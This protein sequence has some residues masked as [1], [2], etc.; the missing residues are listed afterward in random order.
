MEFLI[1][2][3]SPSLNLSVLCPNIFPSTLFSNNFTLC[4]SLSMK[5]HVSYPYKTTAEVADLYI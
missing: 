4:S 3:F 2:Q 1:M 5:D